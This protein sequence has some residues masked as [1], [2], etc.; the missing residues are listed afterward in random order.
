QSVGERGLYA[1]QMGGDFP[2]VFRQSGKSIQWVLRNTAFTATTNTPAAR[3]L[4]RSFSDS[5]LGTAKILSQPHPERKSVLINV[6]DLFITDLPGYVGVLKEV[7]RPTDYRF[8][9]N[10]SAIT[11]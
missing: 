10:N 1:S 7:Y 2:F 5:I 4:A 6:A 3:A 11:S 9:K 8:D